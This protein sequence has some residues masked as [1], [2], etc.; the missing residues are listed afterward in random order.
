MLTPLP[1]RRRPMR[2]LFALSFFMFATSA[3]AAPAPQESWGKPGVSFDQYR[4]DAVECGREGYY[5]DISQTADA[6]EFVRA[7]RQLDTLNGTFS[8]SA[9][10]ANADGPTST[11]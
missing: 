3:V 11:D 9:T 7:S 5:L 8:G 10:T 1:G 2:R 6:K 4:Q